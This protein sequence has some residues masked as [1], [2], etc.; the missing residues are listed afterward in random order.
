MIAWGS[1][2]RALRKHLGLSQ[3]K[4][5]RALGGS[6]Q[7]WISH[8]ESGDVRRQPSM[9]MLEAYSAVTGMPVHE[10]VR[11]AEL[12]LDERGAA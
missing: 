12:G 4:M 1:T 10:I 7:C 5:A 11:R 6:S 2:L 9:E 3:R 8:L